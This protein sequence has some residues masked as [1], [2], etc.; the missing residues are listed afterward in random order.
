MKADLHLHSTASDGTLAPDELVLRAAQEGFELIALTDH[1]SVS[2]VAQAQQAAK[3]SG[4]RLIPGVELSCGADK[5]IHILGYGVDVQN[6]ALLAF[7]AA[8]RGERVERAREMVRRLGENGAPV[9]FERVCEMARGMIGRPH[10]A[11][12]LLEAGHVNSIPEAFERYL[13][14]G[15]C[16]YVPREKIEVAQ[17]VRMI[18]AAGGAAV[19]AHPMELKK[20]EMALTALVGEWKSQGLEGIEV[21]HPSAQ[22]NHAA[23]LLSLARSEGMLV[24][25]G[26]DFHGENVRDSRLGDTLERWRD[27]QEDTQRLLE[28]LKMK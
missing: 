4:V 6:E 9:S 19:L 20:G 17:A 28:R 12:A 3:A 22:N 11:R 8:R 13:T 1:D 15:K 21:Y 27:V 24:T 2:G 18:R 26:S 10:V 7:S 16:A 25:G 5:E 23:F 14:P